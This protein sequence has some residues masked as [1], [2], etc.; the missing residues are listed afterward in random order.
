MLFRTILAI[1]LMAAAVLPAPAATQSQ[2][3]HHRSDYGV[4]YSKSPPQL[5]GYREGHKPGH[6]PRHA[7]AG[8]EDPGSPVASYAGSLGAVLLGATYGYWSDG[9]RIY[10]GDPCY[11]YNDRDW[12][13]E[14]VC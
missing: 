7:A 1:A 9:H 5:A 13:F 12:D 6:R 2:T 3:R 14:R 10:G 4:A 8:D 11:R